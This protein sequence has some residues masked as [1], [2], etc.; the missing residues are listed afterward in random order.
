MNVPKTYTCTSCGV[1]VQ[2][3]PTLLADVFAVKAGICPC[4]RC[5][6]AFTVIICQNVPQ[7]NNGKENHVPLKRPPRANTDS[8]RG[9][10][11]CPLCRLKNTLKQMTNNIAT[12]PQHR[13]L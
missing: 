9:G 3:V 12:K 11:K 8:K 10:Q 2:A 1:P 5:T 7:Y 6:A 4:P 13:V